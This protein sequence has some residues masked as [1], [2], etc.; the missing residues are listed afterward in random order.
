MKV[1]SHC[2][3]HQDGGEPALGRINCWSLGGPTTQPGVRDPGFTLAPFT[4]EF[5]FTLVGEGNKRSEKW[6][7]LAKVS[8]RLI[9]A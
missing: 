7:T 6:K 3:K 1:I 9:V 4:S 2:V 5:R 8:K